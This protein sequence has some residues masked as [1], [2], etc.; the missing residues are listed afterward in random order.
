LRANDVRQNGKSRKGYSLR[1]RSEYND[2]KP[3]L[4]CFMRLLYSLTD[5]I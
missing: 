2:A 3:A 5:N 4:K 1:K